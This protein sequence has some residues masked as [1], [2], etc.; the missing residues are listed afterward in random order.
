MY[1]SG[2]LVTMNSSNDDTTNRTDYYRLRVTLAKTREIILLYSII[3]ELE[4]D[5]GVLSCFFCQTN[6]NNVTT[7]L[8][9]LIYILVDRQRL[10]SRIKQVFED[11]NA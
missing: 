10:F 5:N 8:R 1:T 2:F 6:I 7:V 11:I 9:G 4:K 3:N